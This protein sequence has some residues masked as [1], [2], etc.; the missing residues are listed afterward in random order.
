VKDILWIAMPFVSLGTT[1]QAAIDDRGVM[2]G[3]GPAPEARPFHI[4]RVDPALDDIVA[5]NAELEQPPP[6]RPRA[7]SQS[8]THRHADS[9]SSSRLQ[10]AVSRKKASP[11]TATTSSFS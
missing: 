11:C 7:L 6:C 5:P 8:R 4:E 9:D 10:D 1:V 2:R 3:D